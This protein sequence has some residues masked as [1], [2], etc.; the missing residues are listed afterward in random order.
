MKKK[1]TETTIVREFEN[2]EFY[3]IKY[4]DN[5]ADE[6]GISGFAVY[7]QEELDFWKSKIPEKW[8]FSV[9]TNEEIEYHSGKQFLNSCEIK[10]ISINEAKSLYKFF[11]KNK[12][13]FLDWNG[14]DFER[15][16]NYT[17][18]QFGHFPDHFI[19]PDFEDETEEDE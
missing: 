10:N 7:D 12:T 2:K 15:F 5:W 13:R 3:L 11:G 14:K 18:C 17:D 6:M 16:E 9:G 1:K 19:D 4:S 8:A